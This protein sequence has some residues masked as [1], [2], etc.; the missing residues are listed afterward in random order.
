M[1]DPLDPWPEP[2]YKADVPYAHLHAIGLAASQFASLEGAADRF[3]LQCATEAKFP[4]KVASTYYFSLDEAKRSEQI[5]NISRDIFGESEINSLINNAVD[6][7][8]WCRESRNTLLHS[9]NYPMG[10][11]YFDIPPTTI[12]LTKRKSKQSIEH[13]Y[14]HFTLQQIRD[15]A[16]FMHDCKFL[17][18]DLT[19]YLRYRSR[20]TD[21]RPEDRRL[22][23]SLPEKLTVPPPLEKRPTP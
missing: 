6:G 2:K 12:V 18:L 8:V 16:D 4:H 5:R 13:N 11:R 14:V 9:E 17:I 7:L 20:P 3:F 10:F 23:L 19:I 22:A 21:L 15:T 1:T